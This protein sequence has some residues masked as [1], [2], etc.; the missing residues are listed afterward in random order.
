MMLDAN[1]TPSYVTVTSG[2]NIS[3]CYY[4]LSP[5]VLDPYAPMSCWTSP[6]CGVWMYCSYS[7]FSFYVRYHAININPNAVC[8]KT[9]YNMPINNIACD[10]FCCMVIILDF[11]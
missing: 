5:I 7:S 10:I 9:A 2:V 8:F 11:G 4:Q 3:I 6:A 1:I